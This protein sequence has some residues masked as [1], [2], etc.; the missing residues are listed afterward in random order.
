MSKRRA[1]H[2]TIRGWLTQVVA[3]FVIAAVVAVLALAVHV[4][5]LAGATPYTILTG[6]MAPGMPPGT[7][8]VVRPVDV[9]ELGAGDVIT[10]QLESGKRQV[11]TH[12][13]V[14]QGYDLSGRVVLTTQGDANDVADE[15]PVL[16]VQV[17]GERWYSVPYLGYVS[18]LLTEAQRESAVV[19]VAL[20]LFGYAT[21]MFVGAARE[22]RRVGPSARDKERAA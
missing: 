6:S 12:R 15:N 20:G 21:A 19:V 18:R 13:V 9:A 4:P 16:A 11:V 14:R 17:R 5:R 3:W 8:V 22:R 10:Y 1:D 7:L 2:L